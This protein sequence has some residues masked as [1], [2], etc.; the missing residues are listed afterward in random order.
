MNLWMKISND[1]Y[2]LPEAVAD[3]ST[4][5]AKMCGINR[6]G[7]NVAISNAKRRNSKCQ[8]IKIEVEEE[9]QEGEED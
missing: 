5:L 4:E 9:E 6:N 2:E 3:T 8:Y 1:E 7:V